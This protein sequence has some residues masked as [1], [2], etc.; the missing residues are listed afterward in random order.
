MFLSV[1]PGLRGCGVAIW[2]DANQL[3]RAT[4]VKNSERDLCGP[5]A[6]R[7]MA[8]GVYDYAGIR[9]PMV[10]EWQQ[11]RHSDTP[12]ITKAI[13]EV[14][15]VVGAL[16][17]TCTTDLLTQYLPSEWKGTVAAD[18]LT[19]RIPGSSGLSRRGSGGE[20]LWTTTY[21]M[22]SGSGSIIPGE[23]LEEW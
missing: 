20:K 14:Q 10:I 15:G 2:T 5:I 23:H 21:G 6:W 18:V 3:A 9:L 16:V 13:L 22:R 8:D 7:A 12:A 17:G 1:D 19:E 11:H 4:Y